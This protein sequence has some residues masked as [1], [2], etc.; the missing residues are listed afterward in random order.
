MP[1]GGV[2]L[3]SMPESRLEEYTSIRMPPFKKGISQGFQMHGTHIQVEHFMSRRE[4][5][6]HAIS[7]DF[8][9]DMDDDSALNVKSVSDYHAWTVSPIPPYLIAR[10][11][12]LL[13]AFERMNEPF[14]QPNYIN[15]EPWNGVG[16]ARLIE[17]SI[18]F[19]DKDV[20]LIALLQRTSSNQAITPEPQEA[21]G[22]RGD[23]STT[24]WD[25]DVVASLAY[26][27]CSGINPSL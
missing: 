25:F 23:D 6:T 12:D 2:L 18:R 26:V 10:F 15:S 5:L 11:N 1:F 17:T 7:V 19:G 20:I 14:L 8:F 4:S 9:R 24:E 21:T 16:S 27:R 3:S 22:S 13:D